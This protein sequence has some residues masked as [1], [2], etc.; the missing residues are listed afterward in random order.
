VEVQDQLPLDVSAP[1]L[2]RQLLEPFRDRLPGRAFDD[3]RLVTSELVTNGYRHGAGRGWITVQVTWVDDYVRVAV[4]SLRGRSRPAI[5]QPGYRGGGGGLGLRIV[6]ILS[7]DWGV[8]EHD[9]QIWVWAH[10]ALD[11]GTE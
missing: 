3:L 2:G 6:D 11:S 10:L 9:G 7:R 8:T 5:A 1:R 4:G